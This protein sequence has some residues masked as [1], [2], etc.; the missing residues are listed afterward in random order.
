MKQFKTY[1]KN[2]EKNGFKRFDATID[3]LL[4]REN[5]TD[6]EIE[7][8]K[9]YHLQMPVSLSNS[10]MNKICRRI[11]DEFDKV[12][13]TFIEREFD[14]SIL[15]SDV[16]I[17]K[18]RY[19]A[20]KKL[21]NEYTSKVREYTKSAKSMKLKKDERRSKRIEFKEWF[22]RE[23]YKLC[24]NSKELTNIVV[25]ICYKSD[26]SKQF[27]WDVCGDQ[28]LKNLLEKN[29]QTIHYPVLDQYGEIKF[30]GETYTLVS[31]QL[32]EDKFENSLE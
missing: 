20:V 3:E 31:N 24:S 8:L 12:R 11:E 25:D 23:A 17:S 9:Y 28:I 5:K 2:T 14:H 22:K 7:F 15:M 30:G 10:V 13:L 32:E 26:K 1:L 29:N 4:M 19:A 27:A 21:Y 16:E 6:E 18:G